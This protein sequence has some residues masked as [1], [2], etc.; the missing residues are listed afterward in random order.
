M[1]ATDPAATARRLSPAQKRALLWLPGDGSARK[2]PLT[3]APRESTRMSLCLRELAKE[4]VTRDFHV[5]MHTT[6]LGLAVRAVL[7][8]EVGE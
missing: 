1:T 4:A 3:N 2:L 7:E 8:A 5:A 6:T